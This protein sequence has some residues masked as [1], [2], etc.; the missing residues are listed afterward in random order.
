MLP[1]MSSMMTTVMGWI[2]FEKSVR[3][4]GTSLSSTDLHLSVDRS[5]EIFLTSRQ[6][7]MIR[8]LVA[9]SDGSR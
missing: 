6:D 4:L 3:S 7:G 2:S 8:Q 9:D 5:G 1:L